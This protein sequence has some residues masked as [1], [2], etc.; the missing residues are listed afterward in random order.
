M[1][2]GLQNLGGI[3]DMLNVQSQLLSIG[4]SK[5]NANILYGHYGLYKTLI[6]VPMVI[7]TS[8][9]TTVLPSIS[10][11]KALCDKKEI[12]L[13][14][15]FAYKLALIISIPAAIGLSSVSQLLY[16]SL[17]NNH[18][19]SM[20]MKIGSF[21]LILMS[22]SQIQV[23][24]LQGINKLYYIL[25]TYAIGIIFKIMLNYIFVSIPEINIYGVLI[26]NCAWYLI[27]I[28]LNHKRFNFI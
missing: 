5:D 28:I 17:F 18:N 14:I 3:I 21:I 11:A 24:I 2:S 9:S 13:H 4:L 26:G 20:L 27:P 22:L 23:A 19:V 16:Y 25:C 12:N 1:S 15:N 10:K 7:I 6:G 8:I